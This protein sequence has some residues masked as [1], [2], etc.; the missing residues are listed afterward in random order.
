MR[1]KKSN[2][3]KSFNKHKVCGTIGLVLC[4]RNKGLKFAVMFGGVFLLS[5]LMCYRGNGGSSFQLDGAS[6]GLL[7]SK[8]S[9]ESYNEELARRLEAEA[10]ANAGA[11]ACVCSGVTAGASALVTVRR[12]EAVSR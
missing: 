2:Q 11:A 3:K 7:I 10:A 5:M 1:K 8:L 6:K 9:M 12:A 4:A